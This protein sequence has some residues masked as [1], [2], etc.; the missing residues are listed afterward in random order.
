MSCDEICCNHGCNQGRNCPAR[1]APIKTS[2]PVQ[3]PV[4]DE[5]DV[6]ISPLLAVGLVLSAALCAALVLFGLAVL[7]SHFVS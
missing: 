5:F 3:I 2:T 4:P 6:S 7:Y 1:V